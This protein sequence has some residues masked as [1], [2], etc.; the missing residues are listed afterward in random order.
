VSKSIPQPWRVL[1]DKPNLEQLKNQAKDL[2]RDYSAGDADT[3]A[4]VQR[5]EDTPPA[6]LALADA[7]RVLARAYGY[8]SWAELKHFVDGITVARF[9]DAARVG[10]VAVLRQML[11]VRP[12]LV[13][14]DLA[15]N[16]EHRAIHFAVLHRHAE[17]VRV[18]MEA[19]ADPR[20]GIYPNRSA[21]TALVIAQD[22]GY[23]EIVDAIEKAEQARREAASCPNATV[24]PVQ[25]QITAAIRSGKNDEAI[26]LLSADASLIKAC[27]RD[28]ASPLHIA[29]EALNDGMVAWLLE[30][31]HRFGV[32]KADLAGRM[33]LDRA[34]LAVE[35]RNA[36]SLQ[37]F[38]PVAERFRRA[39]APLTAM[40]AIAMG[41][42]DRLA[43]L[44]REE[45]Q[46]FSPGPE[47]IK[48][49]TIAVRHCRHDMLRLLLDLGL[50]PNQRTTL[51]NVEGQVNSAGEP[52]WLAV[53]GDDWDAA[54]ILLDRGADPNA[55]VYASGTATSQAFGTRNPRM[56]KLMLDHGGELS[57][58]FLG[59]YRQTDRAR[60]ALDETAPI[61]ANPRGYPGPTTAEQLLWG[62]ACGGDPEIVGLALEKIDWAPT[63]ARWFNMAVQPL[64]IW[65]NG[66]GHWAGG[67][68]RSTYVECFRPIIAR[69][70][71]NMV[72]R[73]GQTLLHRVASDGWT[74]GQPVMTSE[75]RL[76]FATIVLDAGAKFD[77][78][79]TVLASTP[80]AWAARWGCG[81]LVE[82]LLSRGASAAETDAEPWATPLAW[83]TRYGH[84]DIAAKLR[85]AG[86]P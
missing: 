15:E 72:S 9:C 1:P 46:K 63:D 74:W 27:D 41:D 84:S 25:D 68:D 81:E 44:F 67:Y 31:A 45:P 71:V 57:P 24:T 48:P 65:N 50:D 85:T 20:K 82:L 22:R 2:L 43:E 83:A 73:H 62:G 34:V 78:R 35:P 42:G 39:G 29:A 18:L 3:I 75:E 53:V 60:R 77:V 55:N 23:G 54:T 21:T 52:L 14:M 17:A 79:D 28:G 26:A 11:R 32:Q 86:A 38:A 37:R 19:G 47:F 70:D 58:D 76:A 7:Q 8:A 33:P 59:L 61:P 6:H 30:P 80:L 69:M 64:R 12:E 40:S 5:A 16:D 4:E 10:D 56:Q 36:D 51:G 49:L 13:G 66:P